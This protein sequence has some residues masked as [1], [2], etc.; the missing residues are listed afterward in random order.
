MAESEELTSLTAIDEHDMNSVPRESPKQE[1]QEKN[2]DKGVGSGETRWPGWPGE[3]VYRMLVPA[4]KVGGIIGRKGEFIKKICEETRVRVK[5]LDAPPG[6]QERVVMVS[7]KEEL[8]SPLPPAI[9][10]L[11]RVHERTLDG[12][13]VDVAQAP[14]FTVS[15]R[16][17]LVSTQAG[18]LIGKQGSTI[19]SIQEASK[20]IVK[21]LGR[22]E[23]PIFALPD[24]KVVEIAGEPSGVHKALELI[25]LHLRK[26]LVDRSV[27]GSFEKEMQQAPDAHLE[28]PLPHESWRPP[29]P[30]QGFNP[31]SEYNMHAQHPRHHDNYYPH[32]ERM[33]R[34]L[35]HHHQGES[36]YGRNVAPPP[37]VTT[38]LQPVPP[39]SIKQMRQNMQV[40]LSYADAVIGEEGANISY[41]RRMSGATITIHETVGV[42]GEMTVEINGSASQVQTAQQLLQNFMAE[43]AAGSHNGYPEQNGRG[44]GAVCEGNYSRHSNLTMS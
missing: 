8:S 42:Q 5:I 35:H 1:Q 32:P 39:L 6:T 40:P 33:D 27:I 17:L 37:P 30:T 9:E 34:Q 21:V 38:N 26:F 15:T 19:K 3:N 10:G 14:G 43:A 22:E 20:T 23:L 31:T 2:D 36:M 25:A 28:P 18:N 12:L 4:Q 29:P 16:L 11:L 24:D 13:D 44:Y 7:A 41:A